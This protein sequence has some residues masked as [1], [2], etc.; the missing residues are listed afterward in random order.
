MM[1]KFLLSIVTLM[2]CLFSSCGEK[3]SGSIEKE[4]PESDHTY[5]IYMIGDNSLYGWCKLNTQKA[6]MGLLESETPVN[7]VIYE[8]S[9]ETNF[10]DVEKGT[11]VLFRL[12]RNFIDKQKVDTIMIHQFEQDHN[13]ADPEVMQSIINEAFAACP[14][15]VKGL[16]IWCHGLGWAPSYKYQETKAAESTRASQWVGP[17]DD[18]Y[19]EIWELRKALEKCPHL[20][21]ITFD[22][23]NM[24]QAEVAYELKG[25]ADYMM[26]CPTEIMAAGLP[27]T[28]MIKIL[29]GV[30]NA[31]ALTKSLPELRDAFQQ[32]DEANF[33]DGTFSILDLKEMTNL[34]HAYK[35]LLAACPERLQLLEEKAYVYEDYMQQFGRTSM[36]SGYLFYDMLT[37]ADFLTENQTE[38]PEYVRWKEAFEKTVL[39]EYH[40]KKFLDLGEITSCGLG[41]GLP[42]VFGTICSDK[43]KL[44]SAYNQ[45]LWS[46]D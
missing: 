20:N 9:W 4:W 42:E 30:N 38:L 14:A 1:K 13:S 29:S 22:A 2:T 32:R 36:G 25:V 3:G 19:M 18:R 45:L 39:Y 37:A 10:K 24:A 40:S 23:C 12:K 6:I 17:D 41:V 5:L 16:E 15:S 35:S 26:A 11:P 28:E 33:L 21:Y 44:L 8:D 34:H 7:L 31:S 27:Y 43:A 46:K